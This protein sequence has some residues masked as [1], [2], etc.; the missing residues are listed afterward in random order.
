MNRR[1]V[2][3]VI[4]LAAAVL[5]GAAAQGAREPERSVTVGSKPHAEQ[6]ILAEMIS[7]LIEEKTDISVDQR[8]G[9][10]G[11]TSNLH[12]AMLSGDIDIYPE[13]TGTGWLFV[14]R[15]DLIEQPDELYEAVKREYQE[16]FSITWLDR[17]GFNNTYALAV[18]NEFVDSY[19]LKTYSDLAEVSG[20]LVFG[21]EYDFFERDDGFNALSEAYGLQFKDTRELDIGLKYQA[22]GSQRVDVINAF[23]TDGLLAEHD[24]TVLE[25]DKYFFPSYEAATIVRAETLQEYPELEGVL[26]LLSGAISDDAMTAMN[27][28]VEELNEDARAV[29][30]D[31]LEQAG[32]L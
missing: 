24:I 30:R 8:L 21:A 15:R 6:Y 20:E 9:I 10:G 17:Y 29:A 22:I 3:I 18:R 7:L 31:F 28:R 26:N 32:L 25:D 5:W 19:G 27:Y 1:V 14:L 12:P 23:S 13:Y 4:I 11:G 16:E 2:F